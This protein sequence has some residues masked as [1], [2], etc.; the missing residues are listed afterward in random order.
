MTKSRARKAGPPKATTK[1][2]TLRKVDA[3]KAPSRDRRASSKTVAENAGATYRKTAA[4]FDEFAR[5]T[6][7]PESVR[8]L[9]QKSVAQTRE[10]Y[11]HSLEAAL[12]SWKRFVVAAGQGAVA[13]HHKAIDIARRNID[14]NFGFAE[15]LAGAKNVAEA[16]DLQTAY[17]RKQF[18][19]FT[20]QASEMPT[21]SI[22]TNVATRSKRR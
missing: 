13:M 1:R 14:N 12:E 18:G 21:N 8:A 7:M 11:V 4:Q 10:L 17:W 5:D 16:M 19:A 6:R 20:A 9:A 22:H 3:G 2:Q 15:S